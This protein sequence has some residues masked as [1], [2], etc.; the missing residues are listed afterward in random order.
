MRSLHWLISIV[1]IWVS[2]SSAA[3]H[4]QEPT[5]MWAPATTTIALIAAMALQNNLKDS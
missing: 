3:A 5:V 1:F 2:S 4:L